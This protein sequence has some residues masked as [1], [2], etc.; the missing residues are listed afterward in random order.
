MESL[1]RHAGADNL[2]LITGPGIQQKFTLKAGKG[3]A[4]LC[5]LVMADEIP[6]YGDEN[7]N[8]VDDA[9]ERQKLGKLLASNATLAERKALGELWRKTQRVLPPPPLFV[10]RPIPDDSLPKPGR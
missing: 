1:L 3:G 6:V 5:Q 10:R 4:W 7:A 8:G 2:P 9:F